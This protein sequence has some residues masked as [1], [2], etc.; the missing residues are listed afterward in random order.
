MDSISIKNQ[1]LFVGSHIHTIDEKKRFIF[2]SC[3]RNLD[4]SNKMYVFPH[5]EL[6]C[7]NIY[8]TD[9][10]NRRLNFLRTETLDKNE[11][12]AI[13]SK[14]KFPDVLK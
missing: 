8:F 12:R 7:L 4:I 5:P 13:T 10:I 11:S 1:N 2:P 3:W 14:L 9:E 6:P